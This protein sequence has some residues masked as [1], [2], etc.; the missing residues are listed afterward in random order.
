MIRKLPGRLGGSLPTLA[1]AVFVGSTIT[2]GVASKSFPRYDLRWL[3]V[4][5][6]IATVIACVCAAVGNPKAKRCRL[7]AAA[8]SSTYI[9]TRA[10]YVQWRFGQLAPWSALFESLA[11]ATCIA[12]AWGRPPVIRGT[13]QFAKDG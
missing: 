11:L 1:V 2:P 10:V 5:W 7:A 12:W 3:W 8:L 13:I 9:L 4:A 6:A